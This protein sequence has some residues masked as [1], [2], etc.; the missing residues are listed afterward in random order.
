VSRPHARVPVPSHL[1]TEVGPGNRKCA[2]TANAQYDLGTFDVV[3]FHENL[4]TLKRRPPAGGAAADAPAAAAGLR[5]DATEAAPLIRA[6]PSPELP[7]AHRSRPPPLAGA[8]ADRYRRVLAERWGVDAVFGDATVRVPAEA[9]L[10]GVL[11]PSAVAWCGAG[12]RF[13]AIALLLA[14]AD[15]YPSKA[16]FAAAK[17]AAV[18]H[19]FPALIL[20]GLADPAPDDDGM[21]TNFGMQC[22]LFR[23]GTGESSRAHFARDGG[24][25]RLLVGELGE[26]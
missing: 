4:V 8:P 22:V 18:E 25:V 21:E 16:S 2:P 15:H 12:N 7:A 11:G 10:Y 19:R 20:Y 13:G 1:Q 24:T 17:A 3:V 14:V 6:T 26:V 23:P 5:Q 9:V